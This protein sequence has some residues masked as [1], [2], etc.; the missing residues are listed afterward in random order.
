MIYRREFEEMSAFPYEYE[1][2]K[3]DSVTFFWQTMPVRV[4]GNSSG[5][6]E[7]LECVRTQPTTF[8]GDGH[9]RRRPE[10]VPGSEFQ[11]EVDMVV[12]ALGQQK[13]TGFLQGIV[14]LEM[15]NGKVVVNRE[16]MRTANPRYF[17]GGDCVNGG[18][19]VVDA[20][21]DGK[22]AALGIRQ[23]LESLR[24]EGVARA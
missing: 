8:N 15:S 12:K 19:E 24:Q 13:K 11:L 4:L 22:R 10:P 23:A 1:L 9:S 7:A 16:D 5:Q 6:V 14:D 18:G 20:V 3:R 2:A 17:A 21:A